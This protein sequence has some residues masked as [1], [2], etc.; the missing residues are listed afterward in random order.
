MRQSAEQD[1][2]EGEIDLVRD[3]TRRRGTR[4]N[5]HQVGGREGGREGAEQKRP[6]T[7]QEEKSSFGKRRASSSA[8]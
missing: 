5:G 4:R 2:G 1:E 8:V 6:S 3:L 7:F